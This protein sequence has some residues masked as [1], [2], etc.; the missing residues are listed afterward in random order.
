MRVVQAAKKV[1]EVKKRESE[2][3]S[4]EHYTK[5]NILKLQKGLLTYRIIV[6]LTSK[7]GLDPI[8]CDSLYRV[9]T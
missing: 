7:R 3:R 5:Q 1:V 6:I 4:V 8:P 9:H 2:P